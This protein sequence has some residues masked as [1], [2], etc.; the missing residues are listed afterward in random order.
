[1]EKNSTNRS[2]KRGNIRGCFRVRTKKG[3]AI[4]AHYYYQE[5][6][7]ENHREEKEKR[8]E[9]KPPLKEQQKGQKGVPL[10]QSSA[11]WEGKKKEKLGGEGEKTPSSTHYLRKNGKIYT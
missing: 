4:A 2:E 10:I 9:G 6:K 11:P 3:D 8:R 5:K 1:L 7:K